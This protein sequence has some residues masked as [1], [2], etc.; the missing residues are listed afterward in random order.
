[1]NYNAAL[2]ASP[3]KHAAFT[4]WLST[5]TVNALQA[6][7]GDKAQ[8]TSAITEYL[9]LATA[10]SLDVEEIEDLLGIN[11]PCIMDLAGLS[12]DDEEIVIDAFEAA[13]GLH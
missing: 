12:D 9:R 10:A 8:L 13:L 2:D 7:R 4:A 11:E 6:A 5:E 1:M 3:E